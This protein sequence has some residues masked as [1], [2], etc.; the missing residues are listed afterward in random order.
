MCQLMVHVAPRAAQTVVGDG[1]CTAAL[2]A[3]DDQRLKFSLESSF[4]ASN[5]AVFRSDHGIGTTCHPQSACVAR[6]IS[7]TVPSS[8]SK[9]ILAL[10]L[11]DESPQHADF[12]IFPCCYIFPHLPVHF[13][14]VHR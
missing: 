8:Q 14:H 11:H 9:G 12:P 6:T 5:W 3:G 7:T 2:C 1:H 4:P 13:I 10:T